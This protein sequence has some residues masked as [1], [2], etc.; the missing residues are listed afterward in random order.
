MSIDPITLEVMRSRLDEI[1]TTMERLLFHSGY[2]PILRESYDGSACILDSSGR[3]IVGSGMPIHIF[4]Y[5]YT[6]QAI[7]QRHG[8]RMH[9]GDVFL[10]NDPY[11]G[12]SLHVPDMAVVTPVYYQS[13]LIA[14]CASIAHKPDLGGLVPGSSGAG[15]RE[16]FHEGILVPGVRYWTND[17]VNPDVEEILRQN[18]RA[19]K[20][21]L[22]DLRAQV[23]C[24]R[25]GGRRLVELCDEY[26]IETILGSFDFL[27]ERA[28]RLLKMELA[29]LPDAEQEAEGFLDSD[30]VDL[31]RPVRFHV[32]VSKRGEEIQFDYSRS[33]PQVKGPVNLR[34]QCSET[35]ALLA[36]LG[37]LDP[38]IPINDG[39]RRAVCFVNPPGL[40]TSAQHPAPI[41]NYFPTICLLYACVQLALSKFDPGRAVAPA[42]LGVGACSLGYE[43]SR[44]GVRAVQY[45]LT[46]SSLGGTTVAD[47]AFG[48]IAIYHITASQPIEI[49]ETEYPVQVTRFEPVVDSAGAG[50]HRGGSGCVR[51]Y[52][53]LAD[54][55]FTL[56]MG[57]FQQGAWGVAGGSGPARASCTLNP[58]TEREERLPPLATRDLV[59][60]D[61]VHLRLPGGGG[62]GSP[63]ERDPHAVL[64]DVR[65]GIVSLA[66][67]RDVYG[68]VLDP[69]ER[70][71]DLVATDELRQA[72]GRSAPAPRRFPTAHASRVT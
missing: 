39:P 30:G 20:E 12:G 27:I 9:P 51:E 32:L 56:R 37:Y 33:D 48:T 40:V 7:L 15:A 63:I 1:V 47:G 6:V 18:S 36:L 31:D 26:G 16:I 53:L 24:T 17:G 28:G 44:R 45:E 11:V 41:N 14:F 71:V 67:A 46:T 65:N 5:Y 72:M 10:L 35:A 62:Y 8:D 29:K 61:V 60:E 52:R 68:V 34:P 4:P 43:R 50:K 2:S 3:V 57:G 49:L 59:P 58:G 22:G 55:K 64:E 42:G 70:N 21:V 19:P 69:T 38:T 23:G 13:Q 25:V 54:A 66:A